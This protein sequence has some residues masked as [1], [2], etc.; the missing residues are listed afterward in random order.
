MYTRSYTLK[1]YVRGLWGNYMDRHP[2]KYLH[3]DERYYEG[4]PEAALEDSP[5][6][7]ESFAPLELSP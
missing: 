4:V 1:P 6:P 5:P 7:V 2:W 3:I